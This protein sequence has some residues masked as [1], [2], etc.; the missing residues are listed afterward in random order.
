MT[1]RW[2][3]SRAGIINVYQY[4]DETLEFAG[5]RLLLRGVN[6][7]GKSTAMNMLLPFLLDTNVRRI[8]AAGEQQNVLRSWMLSGREEPQPVGYL[9]I[10]LARGSDHVV[11][12]CGIKA[13]RSTDRV[14]TWWFVTDR[15]PGVDLALVEGRVPLSVEALRAALGATAVFT[16]DQRAAYRTEV[17]ARLFGGAD[18]DQHIRLLNVVRNPR[19]GDRIDVELPTYLEQALPQLSDSAIDDAAQPLED[20]EE[21]R[22]NVEDMAR[23]KGTLDAL[24]EGYGAY[25]RAELRRR[26][27]ALLD[28]FGDVR[29]RR[30]DEATARQRA[31]AAV[32]RVRDAGDDVARLEGDLVRFRVEIDSLREAP[33]YKEGQSLVDLRSMVTSLTESL[34]HAEDGVR[35]AAQRLEAASARVLTDEARAGQDHHVLVDALADLAVALDA[36]G[37]TVAPIDAPSPARVRLDDGSG[38][39]VHGPD[40]WSDHGSDARSDSTSDGTSVGGSGHG[41][42]RVRSGTSEARAVAGQRQVDIDAVLRLLDVVDRLEAALAQAEADLSKAEQHATDQ[43]RGF[44]EAREALATATETWRAALTAWAARFA[45]EAEYDLED[46]PPPVVD[47]DLIARPDLVDQAD[48][49]V[50]ALA[51]SATAVADRHRA[52]AARLA[53]RLASEQ[54]TA[55]A[56]ATEL[57]VLE[58][59]TEPEAPALPWQQPRERARL[60]DLVDFAPG[61]D[62]EAAAGL[63]A[64]MEAAGLLGAELEPDGSLVLST[65]ELVATPA[66]PAR[67]PLSALLVVTVPVDRHA[68]ID[69]GA[70]A[71]LLDAVSTS[72]ADDTVLAVTTDGSFRSGVLRGRHHKALAEHIGVTNRRAALERRRAEVAAQLADATAVVAGTAAELEVARTRI[73]AALI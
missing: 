62:G 39:A 32:Q 33:A 48:T 67:Q 13:N 41:L 11:C 16:H 69:A 46:D 17:Q 60:A 18:I 35:R 15:R 4:A 53:G 24:A 29:S 36:T 34:A 70:V 58:Q 63:E 12:G 1:A 44:V 47:P 38:A 68:D 30:T 45:A 64:A 54:D 37:I 71:S 57:A 21:H 27:G 3:L 49:T 65:G 72:L 42:E 31:T 55:D 40:G 61:L 26:A 28:A 52:I 50:A 22:R 14:T 6:G 5:G 8:D 73:A 23:T 56:L 51:D 43:E 19:V 66:G 10:E 7:S 9:W 59:R 20:L 25:A 2:V